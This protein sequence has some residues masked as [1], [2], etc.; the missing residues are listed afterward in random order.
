MKLILLD[1]GHVYIGMYE[2]VE[3]FKQLKIYK[4]KK[5]ALK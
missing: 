1:Y 3:V 4:K 2:R 5:T